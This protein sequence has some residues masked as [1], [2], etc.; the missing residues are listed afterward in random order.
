MGKAEKIPRLKSPPAPSSSVMSSPRIKFTA[1]VTRKFSLISAQI[2]LYGSERSISFFHLPERLAAVTGIH[3]PWGA[4]Q[5]SGIPAARAAARASML[6]PGKS[7]PPP[8]SLPPPASLDFSAGMCLRRMRGGLSGPTEADA[9]GAL[10]RLSPPQC[11]MSAPTV[12]ANIAV[13]STTCFSLRTHKPAA[14][15]ARRSQAYPRRRMD[16]VKESGP[17]I[18]LWFLLRRGALLCDMP[19]MLPSR[20]GGARGSSERVLPLSHISLS[21]TCDS[22]SS[23]SCLRRWL[24]RRRIRLAPSATTPTAARMGRATPPDMSQEL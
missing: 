9:G 16:V 14:T 7:S 13:T 2:S 15:V 18:L 24:R 3:G 23:R 19:A 21:A 5:G 10:P 20:L 4:L 6:I 11:N 22:A 17:D 12:K 1:L 8:P